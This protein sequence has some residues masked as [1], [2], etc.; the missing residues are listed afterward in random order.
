MWHSLFYPPMIWFNHVCHPG[1]FISNNKGH[2]PTDTQTWFQVEILFQTPWDMNHIVGGLIFRGKNRTSV[3]KTCFCHNQLMIQHHQQSQGL[4][5]IPELFHFQKNIFILGWIAVSLLT[6][7]TSLI[8]LLI[9]LIWMVARKGLLQFR[10]IPD[11][12]QATGLGK[13]YL[14]VQFK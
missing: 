6:L 3:T 2:W 1:N 8:F 10:N 13:N 12:L 9:Q 5:L 14:G 4:E 7:D 11:Q